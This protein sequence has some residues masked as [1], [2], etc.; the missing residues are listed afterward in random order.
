[1]EGTLPR[2]ETGPE[3][4]L[5]RP[6]AAL[7]SEAGLRGILPEEDIP[8]GIGTAPIEDSPVRNIPP[9]TEKIRPV[10]ILSPT[11]GPDRTTGPTVTSQETGHSLDT[12]LSPTGLRADLPPG[13][14]EVPVTPPLHGVGSAGPL[15]WASPAGPALWT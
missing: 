15:Q 4:G 12:V 11:P 6:E 7:K 5:M 14:K 10:L 3:D 13:G 1:M 9:R 2:T 8:P